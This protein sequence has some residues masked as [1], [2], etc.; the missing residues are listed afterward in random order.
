MRGIPSLIPYHTLE[1]I[2]FSGHE[3]SF[4][5]SE[6]VEGE[7]L[8]AYLDRQAGQ[9]LDLFQALHLLHQLTI[10]IEDIHKHKEYHGDLHAG[11]VIVR[12]MGLS[13]NVKLLDFFHWGKPKPANFKEDIV[14]VIKIFYDTLAGSRYYRTSPRIVKEICCGLTPQL[15]AKKFKTISHLRQ[16]LENLKWDNP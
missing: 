2:E 16:H 6:F 5:V 4:L 9:R 12:R 13:F 15:I 7:I 14:E 8:E 10:A 11:N 3:I 1:L